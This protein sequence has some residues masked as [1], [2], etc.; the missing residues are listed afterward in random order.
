[1]KYYKSLDEYSE[2]KD[3]VLTI[4]KFDGLH[5]GHMLLI[6]D[7]IKISKSRNL[8]STV[9]TMDF[10]SHWKSKGINPNILM[11]KREK[12]EYLD[13][14]VDCLAV[15]IFNETFMKMNAET[16]IREVIVS[17]FHAKV[18]VVGSDFR[19]GYNKCGDVTVLQNF[20]EKYGYET[21][22]VGKMQYDNREVS[23]SYIK[24]LIE[25]G[26]IETANTLL[27]YKYS[28]E[29][30]VSKGNRIGRTLGFPTINVYPDKQ[31]LL[32]P[33][34]V[35][36]VKVFIRGIWY[37]GI[38]NL[39]V[40]P[41]INTNSDTIIESYLFDYNEDAY[42]EEVIISLLDYRRPEK[43]FAS[44]EEMKKHVDKDI[45]YGKKYFTSCVLS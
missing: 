44:L 45:E 33:F 2:T 40:K 43:K 25:G 12:S 5:K 34:G 15:A 28:Y 14:K 38:A 3:S 23:S 10:E 22:V 36:V 26:D 29:G 21:I 37:N 16:F 20:E 1:M 18:V 6:N 31:K 7:I 24:E 4:G 42:D 17:K 32:P 13:G 19:F 27:G 39:G 9:C 11:T 30:I 41:T 8:I 35:Y